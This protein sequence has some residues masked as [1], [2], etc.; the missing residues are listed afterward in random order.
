VQE[1]HDLANHLLLGPAGDD[2]LRAFRADP[3]DLA[4]AAGLLLEP[5]SR[6][7][8]QSARTGPAM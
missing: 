4:Q 8:K 6:P 5:R 1:Q 7:A 3:G 2:P